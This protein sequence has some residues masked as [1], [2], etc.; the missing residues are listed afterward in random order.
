MIDTKLTG[1]LSIKTVQSLFITFNMREYC[2]CKVQGPMPKVN[3]GYFLVYTH[4][5]IP[6]KYFFEGI[7]YYLP[8]AHLKLSKKLNIWWLFL[9]IEETTSIIQRYELALTTKPLAI[10]FIQ[11]FLY[12][13]SQHSTVVNPSVLNCTAYKTLPSFL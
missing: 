1:F 12:Q 5:G 10:E 4:P 3:S 2:W 7:M 6:W 13:N 8:W 9:N 11:C